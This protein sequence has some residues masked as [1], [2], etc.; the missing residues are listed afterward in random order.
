MPKIIRSSRQA[1][2]WERTL[3]LNHA[4]RMPP[5]GVLIRGHCAGVVGRAFT[6]GPAGFPSATAMLA[7][8]RKAG[9]LRTTRAPS[10]V[11]YFWSGGSSN[12]GHVALTTIGSNIYT[13][14][15]PRVGYI[16]R[17]NIRLIKD[18]WGLKPEGWCYAKDV[19][20][21]T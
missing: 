11:I 2:K 20:G 21:W 16:G 15:M 1:A 9:K 6:N 17:V 19:P 14:D 3:M 10:G 8:V 4:I 5:D 13:N 12:F 18:R 7:A